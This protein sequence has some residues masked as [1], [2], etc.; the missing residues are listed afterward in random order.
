MVG[1]FL[2]NDYVEKALANQRNGYNCAQA[3]LSA[4]TLMQPISVKQM[5]IAWLKALVQDWLAVS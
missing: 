2:V 4:L 1:E 5:P 3:G